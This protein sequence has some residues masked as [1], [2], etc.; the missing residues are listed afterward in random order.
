M[1]Q[2][3]GSGDARLI[4]LLDPA[5]L[6]GVGLL[7]LREAEQAACDVE[8]LARQFEDRLGLCRKA[9]VVA[10]KPSADVELGVFAVVCWF[11]EVASKSGS[12]TQSPQSLQAKLFGTANGG[13]EFFTRLASI[14]PQQKEVREVYHALLCL[15]FEGRYFL[16]NEP[17]GPLAKLR[18]KLSPGLPVP[19]LELGPSSAA[20]ICPQP[21]GVPDIPGPRTPDAGAGWWLKPLF[22][23]AIVVPALMALY[24]LMGGIG[25]TSVDPGT[26]VA[27]A[28]AGLRCADLQYRVGADATVAVTGTVAAAADRDGLK[29]RLSAVPSVKHVALDVQ[30]R[31]RRYCDVEELIGE[32]SRAGTQD[33]P[34]VR[35]L[36]PEGRTPDPLVNGDPM[37]LEIV[38]PG[39]AGHVQVDYYS[40]DGMVTRLYPGSWD[41]TTYAAVPAGARVDT[42]SAKGWRIQPPFGEELIVVMTS[43]RPLFT[44]RMGESQRAPEYLS[45]LRQALAQQAPGD[46]FSATLV[47]IRTRDS[48]K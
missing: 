39:F 2:L 16:E 14:G 31:P 3:V 20:P 11:D 12:A 36:L 48:G 25:K 5:I 42:G 46:K 33:R 35:F 28:I 30:V 26:Q 37:R 10:G 45:Q 15:G 1:S 22:A 41:A 19:P 24:P 6:L 43:A 9:A 8:E 21:L 34:A 7:R 38:Q 18:A 17:G 40:L 47:H 44:S 4:E 32:S 27:A 23:M 29:S 13:E